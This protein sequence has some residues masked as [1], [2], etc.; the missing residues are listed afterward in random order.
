MLKKRIL[1]SACVLFSTITLFSFINGDFTKTKVKAFSFDLPDELEQL[2]NDAVILKFGVHRLPLAVYTEHTGEIT[3][4]LNM[5]QDTIKYKKKKG[6]PPK[7]PKFE[8][9]F[10]KSSIMNT[11]DNIKWEM[12]T[13]RIIN[14]KL[15]VSFEFVGSLSG[16]DAKGNETATRN[17]NFLQYCFVENKRYIMNF[18]CPYA[19]MKKWQPIARHVMNS[20]KISN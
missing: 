12:D 13:L 11:Y 3:F 20:I 4:S 18:A 17:Y 9:M 15:M 7:D 8:G 16:Q 2:N 5:D 14:G 10:L 1:L 6:I 19:E